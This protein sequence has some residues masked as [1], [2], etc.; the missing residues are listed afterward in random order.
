M[1][2]R[3]VFL[4]IPPGGGGGGAGGAILFPRLLMRSRHVFL[5]I[6]PGGGGGGRGWGSKSPGNAEKRKKQKINP[7]PPHRGLGVL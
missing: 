1:R 3:H 2:S 6:P 7:T 5:L 4:L